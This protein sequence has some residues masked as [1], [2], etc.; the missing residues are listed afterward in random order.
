ML[1]QVQHQ[2]TGESKDVYEMIGKLEQIKSYLLTQAMHS[3]VFSGL[4]SLHSPPSQQPSP[5]IAHDQQALVS[6][7]QTTPLIT[8]QQVMTQ[9]VDTL[10]QP[11]PMVVQNPASNPQ[12]ADPFFRRPVHWE[13]VDE[14][15]FN[16]VDEPVLWFSKL[17]NSENSQQLLSVPHAKIQ[18]FEKGSPPSSY[19]HSPLF[20]G[21]TLPITLHSSKLEIIIVGAPGLLY[22]KSKTAMHIYWP[23]V[24]KYFKESTMIDVWFQWKKHGPRHMLIVKVEEQVF[25]LTWLFSCSSIWNRSGAGIG[26]SGA[27]AEPTG[28]GASKRPKLGGV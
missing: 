17:V 28:A 23:S 25:C 27:G 22:N 26:P 24:G 20:S 10:G 7:Q 8:G 9:A 2:H 21:M 1:D 18:Y 3:N 13:V 6:N 11:T 16:A 19:A 15:L 14:N 5:P 4:S 12:P